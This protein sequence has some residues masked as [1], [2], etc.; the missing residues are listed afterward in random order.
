MDPFLA[1]L[2]L[3]DTREMVKEPLL[4]LLVLLVTFPMVVPLV[5]HCALPENT[6]VLDKVFALLAN[7]APSLTLLDQR[8]ALNA[9]LEPILVLELPHVLHVLREPTPMAITHLTAINALQVP[10]QQQQELH[11]VYLVEQEH[12]LT[13]L[14]QLLVP[15][16]L[17]VRPV[18]L[19]PTLL[20]LVCKQRSSF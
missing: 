20:L 14:D 10:T 4:A 6:A 1:L 5:A 7:L 9:H 19:V 15:H 17:L 16:V 11:H 18:L 12:I 3:L 13:N 2:V 8:L